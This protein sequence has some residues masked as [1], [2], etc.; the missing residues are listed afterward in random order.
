MKVKKNGWFVFQNFCGLLRICELYVGLKFRQRPVC[1]H[2][3]NFLML[4]LVLEKY[5]LSNFSCMFLNPSIFFNIVL[6]YE[7]WDTS[8]NKYKS[9]LSPN[10][11]LTFHCL[12]KLFQWS[13]PQVSK[14]FSITRTIF[15]HNRSEIFW[16][17][18]TNG[19]CTRKT[20]A[21]AHKG[22]R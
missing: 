12:N 4:A 17:Q 8:R 6:I 11:V 20:T 10:I 13:Q 18:N 16:K 15:S 19:V 7:I 22:L 3:K 21:Y 14:V 1:L 2:Q 5:F 9:I